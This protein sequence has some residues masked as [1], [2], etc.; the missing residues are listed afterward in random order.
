MPRNRYRYSVVRTP[1]ARSLRRL[2]R[3]GRNSP[4]Y[5]PDGRYPLGLVGGSGGERDAATF[6]TMSTKGAGAS[7][8]LVTR[9]P[10]NMVVARYRRGSATT[11]KRGKAESKMSAMA[12]MM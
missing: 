5:A 7:P 11:L 3:R 1:Y 12:R 9:T 10:P 2:L 8:G 4:P 6:V